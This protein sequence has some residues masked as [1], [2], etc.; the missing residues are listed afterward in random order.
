[1]D[2]DSFYFSLPRDKENQKNRQEFA[3]L[4]RRV[5]PEVKCKYEKIYFESVTF[6]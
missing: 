6:N 1:M 4:K 2:L 5:I 3:S